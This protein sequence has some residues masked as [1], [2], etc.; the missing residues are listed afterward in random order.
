MFLPAES[1]IVFTGIHHVA[2]LV[3]NLERSVDFYE[4]LLGEQYR[5]FPFCRKLPPP[6]PSPTLYPRCAFAAQQIHPP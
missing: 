2:V 6:P 5:A 4:G 1:A 3:A